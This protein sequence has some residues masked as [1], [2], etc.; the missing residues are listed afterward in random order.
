MVVVVVVMVVVVFQ[1]NEADLVVEL[2]G[3]ECEHGLCPKV[4]VLKLDTD[5]Y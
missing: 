3:V 1:P 2:V 4:P 5:P